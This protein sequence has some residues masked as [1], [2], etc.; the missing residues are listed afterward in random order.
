[1]QNTIGIPLSFSDVQKNVN[2]S[3]HS[4]MSAERSS[5]GLYLFILQWGAICQFLGLSWPLSRAVSETFPLRG[6]T[7]PQTEKCPT[8]FRNRTSTGPLALHWKPPKPLTVMPTVYQIAN[9]LFRRPLRVV[10]RGDPQVPEWDP[11]EANAPRF[12]KRARSDFATYEHLSRV[13]ENSMEIL[14][15]G[16]TPHTWKVR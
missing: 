1:M 5:N 4:C 16:D 7:L 6:I 13:Y 11:P 9:G 10:T 12:S 14:R 8:T 15:P 2:A 3:L